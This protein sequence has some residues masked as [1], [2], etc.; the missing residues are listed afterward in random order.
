MTCLTLMRRTV[1]GSLLL[2]V[3]A[4][5]SGPLAPGDPAPDFNLTSQ[6]GSQVSLRSYKGSWVILFFFRDHSSADVQLEAR[7]FQRD[8]A[9]YDAFHAVIVGIG[10]TS[11]ESNRNWAD[12]NGLTFTL[13]SDP[14]QKVANAYTVQADGPSS[15][16]DGGIYEMFV[17][18]DGRVKLP[19]IVT[20]D[21]DGESGNLL[22]CLQYFKDQ[23]ERTGA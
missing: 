17:A 8:L 13:L 10:S 19:R 22:A 5:A 15:S 14:D 3:S 1:Y 12:M 4:F 20:Y 23:T 21:F 9:K 7:N 6:S 18:T 11:P 16:G 2:G